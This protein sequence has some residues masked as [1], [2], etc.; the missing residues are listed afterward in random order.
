MSQ[1]GMIDLSSI[2]VLCI[3]EDTV[4]RSV[5]RSALQRHHCKDV[6]QAHGGME[7]LDLCAGRSFDLAICDFQMSPMTGLEFLRELANTGLAEGWPVILLAPKPTPHC[8]GGRATRRLCLGRQAGLRADTDRADRFGVTPAW[9]D[10]LP[11]PQT[12]NCEQWPIAAMPI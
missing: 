10:R 7:A 1:T 3:D 2:R 8:P 4:I 5:I 6:V 11:R 9:P 12:L